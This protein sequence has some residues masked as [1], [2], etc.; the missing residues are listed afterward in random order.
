MNKKTV[1]PLLTLTTFWVVLGCVIGCGTYTEDQAETLARDVVEDSATF[2]YDGIQ[3]TLKLKSKERLEEKN[4]WRF[5][6]E[7]E[8]RH[9]GYGDRTDQMVAQVI[10]PHEAAITVKENKVEKAVLD[11]KWD[12]LTQ[13]MVDNNS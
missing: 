11:E 6:F 2:Q 13:S 7:F 3:E 8:S 10:T 9:A 12:I 5:I 4:T 1:L